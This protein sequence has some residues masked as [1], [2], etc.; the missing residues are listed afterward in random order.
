[1]YYKLNLKALN[2]AMLNRGYS[3]S[4]LSRECGVGKATISRA[5]REQC[6]SRPE[7]I[8]KIAKALDLQV[9]SLLEEEE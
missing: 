3:I 9:E 4:R 7:T 2:I 1:M 6:I 8:Y 5:L